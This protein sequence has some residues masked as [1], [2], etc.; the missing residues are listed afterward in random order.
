LENNGWRARNRFLCTLAS[1]HKGVQQ[2]NITTVAAASLRAFYAGVQVGQVAP[3]A[4]SGCF[5]K[6]GLRTH[7]RWQPL[8]DMGSGGHYTR[9]QVGR[10]SEQILKKEG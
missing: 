2:G 5:A 7:D 9:R 10:E 6:A 8:F 4:G 1:L 3:S